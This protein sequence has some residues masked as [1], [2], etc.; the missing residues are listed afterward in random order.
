MLD[1]KRRT[2]LIAS[3]LCLLAWQTVPAPAHEFWLEPASYQ[4]KRGETVSISIRI[5]EKF[6]GDSFPYVRE[7]FK[8]FVVVTA[9]GEQP[10]KGVLG[11]DPAVTMKFTTPGLTI[12]AH[13]STA[14]PLTFETWEKFEAYLQLEG[15]QQIGLLHLK[16]GKPTTNI[17]ESYTRC[18][19]LLMRV[20]GAGGQDR[21]I[22]MPLE[23]VAESDPYG[24]GEG[25][26]LPVRLFYNGK[27]LAD[28][29]IS[30]VSKVNPDKRHVVRTD[31]TGKA[32]IPLPDRG[33][34]L[35][36]AV[37]MIE[38]KSGAAVQWESIWASMT[39]ARP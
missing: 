28:V 23:L 19:K 26:P 7:E 34:W 29:Q 6:N 22:G 30:A 4:P 17:K 38:P 21:L 20:D 9:R 24:L 27:P 35:L 37:H 14:E 3:A 12:F 36:N 13:H 33:G 16:Q 5:G 2:R 31:A 15:L 11:D 10:V 18:A 8:R 25:Q 32:S 1:C 39:F